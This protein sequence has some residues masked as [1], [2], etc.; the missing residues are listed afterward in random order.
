MSTPYTSTRDG[1]SGQQEV[2]PVFLK[3]GLKRLG[4][5]P[6]NFPPNL[7]RRFYF[8]FKYV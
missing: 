8:I 2:T 1:M 3:P 4:H 6:S 5:L 7:I